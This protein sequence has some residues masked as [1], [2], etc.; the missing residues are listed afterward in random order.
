MSASRQTSK[1]LGGAFSK[2]YYP[3][4]MVVTL[5]DTSTNW[6]CGLTQ[7]TFTD[8]ITQNEVPY[9]STQIE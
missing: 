5:L 1:E 2:C 8:K 4:Y 9:H 6:D 3:P 7:I